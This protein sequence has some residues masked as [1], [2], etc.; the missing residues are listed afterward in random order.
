[1]EY[2]IYDWNLLLNKQSKHFNTI[3]LQID[4]RWIICLSQIL[5]QP[6]DGFVVNDSLIKVN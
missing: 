1:M 2:G 3:K 6:P 4:C 5:A